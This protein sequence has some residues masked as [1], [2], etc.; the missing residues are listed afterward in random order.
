M[1]SRAKAAPPASSITASSS[2]TRARWRRAKATIR[3]IAAQSLGLAGLVDEQGA[4]GHHL[5]AGLQALG[6][7]DHAVLVR[8]GHDRAKAQSPV[9]FEHP[10]PRR[11][12]FAD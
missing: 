7:L 12:T 5:F 3:F 6:D 2:T 4:L 10:H 1:L 11:V 8:A 9:G